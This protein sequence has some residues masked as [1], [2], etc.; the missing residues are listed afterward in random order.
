M[1]SVGFASRVCLA[2]GQNPIA[3]SQ[4]CQFPDTI[5]SPDGAEG[6]LRQIWKFYAAA[7]NTGTCLWGATLC[8][9]RCV[10]SATNACQPHPPDGC[11]PTKL[12]SERVRTPMESP[13]LLSGAANG[14]EMNQLEDLSHKMSAR[15]QRVMM[16]R[17]SE[18]V[19]TIGPAIYLER[20]WI[21]A[22]GGQPH[23]CRR[24]FAFS[25]SK[26]RDCGGSPL[27]NARRTIWRMWK[28]R[29]SVNAISACV[30]TRMNLKMSGQT[31]DNVS[32]RRCRRCRI[33][34][35]YWVRSDCPLV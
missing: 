6:P 31:C 16:L 23:H 15:L 28:N 11:A 12:R 14:S 1:T 25:R 32:R 13:P 27:P 30:A 19:W 18:P 5:R 17:A 29:M 2:N 24:I 35:R 26:S 20:A 34:D 7:R 10:S 8:L 21:Q 33:E 22:R 9:A 3:P 4:L